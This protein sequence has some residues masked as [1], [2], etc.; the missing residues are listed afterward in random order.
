M[1]ALNM[2]EIKIII[3]KDAVEMQY[4][5]DRHVNVKEKLGRFYISTLLDSSY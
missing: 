5:N 2:M 4:T 3:F 1:N